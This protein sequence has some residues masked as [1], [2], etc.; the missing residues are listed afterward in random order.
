[1]TD[2]PDGCL[3]ARSADPRLSG[4]LRQTGRAGRPP[5]ASRA[6]RGTAP[7]PELA[8]PGQSQEPARRRPAYSLRPPDKTGYR[9]RRLVAELRH[10]LRQASP[11]RPWRAALRVRLAESGDHGGLTACI[12]AGNAL[13]AVW[14][15]S[16]LGGSCREAAAL[17]PELRRIIL[18][19][20]PDERTGYAPEIAWEAVRRQSAGG[21]R[22]DAAS[23]PF[24][25][26][27]QL[28]TLLV[29]AAFAAPPNR[30]GPISNAD[31]LRQVGRSR[32]IQRD[33]TRQLLDWARRRGSL[34]CSVD[35]ALGMIDDAGA[36]TRWKAIALLTSHGRLSRFTAGVRPLRP[37]GS[38]ATPGAILDL[39]SRAFGRS[40][41][42]LAAPGPVPGRAASAVFRCG[43]HPARHEPDAGRDRNAS[44][45]QASC[46]DPERHGTDRPLVRARSRSR[47]AARAGR[48][49][50]RQS[51]DS[52]AAGVP[53]GGNV[54]DQGAQRPAGSFPRRSRSPG[55]DAC[56][57]VT[58]NCAYSSRAAGAGGNLS[59]LRPVR[60]TGAAIGSA[61]SRG[62][63]LASLFAWRCC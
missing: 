34:A 26:F 25:E 58:G 15:G 51:R 19:A 20:P 7:V 55:G 18:T 3:T 47:Q 44:R 9:H 31:L 28:E 46:V 59:H 29:H 60:E 63:D 12:V 53:E 11:G 57:P 50:L 56:G 62:R 22:R 16:V 42:E 27:G 21:R 48:A 52:Q 30:D 54:R 61:T 39:V 8:E 24:R 2:R 4:A 17:F 6:P 45:R 14:A 40:R 5:A 1:M 32:Q 10:R 13:H 35:E 33:A 36:D 23:L 49:G 41:G 43:G 37:A 38:A